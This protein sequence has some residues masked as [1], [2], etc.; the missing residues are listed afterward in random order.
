MT[1]SNLTYTWVDLP[2]NRWCQDS[3]TYL[4]GVPYAASNAQECQ[5]HCEKSTHCAGFSFQNSN[6]YCILVKHCYMSS[7]TVGTH[8]SRVKQYTGYQVYFDQQCTNTYYTGIGTVDSVNQFPMEDCVDKCEVYGCG[9][10][11]MDNTKRRCTYQPPECNLAPS[12]LKITYVKIPPSPPTQAPTA[13]SATGDTFQREVD[14]GCVASES[15]VI[16][17][18]NFGT[19]DECENVCDLTADCYI[20]TYTTSSGDCKLYKMCQPITSVGTTVSLR[21]RSDVDAIQYGFSCV[22][23]DGSF[24]DQKV[25]VLDVDACL[26][27]CRMVDGCKYMTMWVTTGNCNLHT[28]CTPSANTIAV[29]YTLSDPLATH[30]LP[31]EYLW[32]SNATGTLSGLGHFSN[33]KYLFFM[34]ET[35]VIDVY[36]KDGVTGEYTNLI[37]TLDSSVL[38][39]GIR[40]VRLGSGDSPHFVATSTSNWFYVFFATSLSPLTYTIFTPGWATNHIMNWELRGY[41]SEDGTFVCLNRVPDI[42]CYTCNPA[43]GACTQITNNYSLRLYKSTTDI[44]TTGS[45]NSRFGMTMDAVQTDYGHIIAAAEL[46]ASNNN[47]DYDGALQVNNDDS[48]VG[49][50]INYICLYKYRSSDNSI[51]EYQRIPS[52]FYTSSQFG[53]AIRFSEDGSWLFVTSSLRSKAFVYRNIGDGVFHL[54][55]TIE[56][57]LDDQHNF[58]LSPTGNMFAVGYTGQ[59]SNRPSIYEYHYQSSTDSYELAGWYGTEDIGDLLSF[60][61]AGSYLYA[62]IPLYENYGVTLKYAVTTNVPS[63]LVVPP[64]QQPTAAPTITPRQYTELPSTTCTGGVNFVSANDK[65][66]SVQECKDL[67]D[68]YAP[69]CQA[70]TRS[71]TTG[72]C[73]LYNICV[74]SA[75]TN[76]NAYIAHPDTINTITPPN[77]T[78]CFNRGAALSSPGVVAH[79]QRD[80]VSECPEVCSAYPT[81][82]FFQFHHQIVYYGL[83]RP[84]CVCLEYCS[85]QAAG[86]ALM[87]YNI[88]P[89]CTVSSDCKGPN[90]YCTP[91]NSCAST[92]CTAHTDCVGVFQ[93]G[94]LPYCANNGYCSDQFTGTCSGELDCNN[95]VITRKAATRNIGVV[96]Q[97]ISNTNTTQARQTVKTLATRVSQTNSSSNLVTTISATETTTFNSILF[98]NV[99]DDALLLEEIKNVACGNLTE[100]CNIQ[101]VTGGG[102]RLQGGG[103]ITVSITY[104]IDSTIYDQIPEGSFNDPEFIQAL[105]DAVGLDPGNV[106]VV[107]TGSSFTVQYAVTSESTTDDPLTEE[108]LAAIDALAANINSV[109]AAVVTELG[110]DESSIE[111][112]QVDKCSDRDCNGRGTCNPTTG[113]CQCTDP[114]YWGVNCETLIVCENGGTPGDGY[115]ACVFPFYGLRC[116]T[117]KDCSCTT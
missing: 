38:P 86:D 2:T 108:A 90:E 14:D 27:A 21:K 94:K 25:E 43:T 42:R 7:Q 1:T 91:S 50:D 52:P 40:S 78:Q 73:T 4:P 83:Q 5:A 16:G 28:A 79:E 47:I 84:G 113:A 22:T 32:G 23:N 13:L 9:A 31:L 103:A 68:K 76:I 109:T 15:I 6:S 17:T 117:T 101:I 18:Y 72:Q 77:G 10:I 75:S 71:T 97:S 92:P 112:T 104:E 12:N 60:A 36:E 54:H 8:V 51:Y 110:I 55:K 116:Q 29:T 48:Q 115:C 59:G 106:T 107:S 67:C 35:R 95:K 34:R 41:I 80:Y 69:F 98:D 39:W 44:R 82:K 58:Y 63:A 93:A 62:G 11:N 65:S 70:S 102:R 53:F 57:P 87:Y 20:S 3:Y 111:A 46:A 66:Y 99:G 49:L 96:K 56:L 74:A 85:A 100:L 26:D 33:E 19:I 89:Q 37:T 105:A 30:Q 88:P 61:Y 64:T 24:I 81:A 114:D 45:S